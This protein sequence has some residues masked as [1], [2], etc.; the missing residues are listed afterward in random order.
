[1]ITG[2][3]SRGS[4]ENRTGSGP[5]TSRWTSFGSR[6][7]SSRGGR[8][9]YAQGKRGRQEF[10]LKKSQKEIFKELG[11]DY[12]HF[13]I[14][15]ENKDTLEVI[16]YLAKQLHMK[17][18]A[19]QF[20][21]NKDRRAVTSQRVSVYRVFPDKLASLNRSLRNA[22]VGDYIFQ[23]DKL[24]L[25]DLQ[26]NAF[27]IT[28]RDCVLKEDA[29]EAHSQLEILRER[30]RLGMEAMS[31][32]GFINYFGLQRF[33][34]FATRTDHIGKKLLQG[35][36]KDAVDSILEFSPA[37]L[38]AATDPESGPTISRDDRDRA[39]A[40]KIFRGGGPIKQALDTLPRKFS[41]ESNILRWLGDEEHKNDYRG[42]LDSIPRNLRSMYVHAYQSLI[43]NLAVTHRW[44]TLGDRLVAGDLVLVN[45]HEDKVPA[46][47]NEDVDAE[48][49][50]V[51][52]P[53]EEDRAVTANERFER[54]RALTAEEVA[55]GRYTIFDVVFPTPGFDILYPEYML[56][57]YKKTM[58][59]EQHGNLDPV[60]MVRKWK[61]ISL[62]GSYRKIVARP[63]AGFSWDVCV[64]EGEDKQLVSTDLDTVHAQRATPKKPGEEKLAIVTGTESTDA[65]RVKEQGADESGVDDGTGTGAEQ[66][67]V[68][69]ASSDQLPL[70]QVPDPAAVKRLGVVLNFKLG[71]S[72]YATMALRELMKQ[73]GAREYKPDFSAGRGMD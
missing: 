69:P 46:K 32:K 64:Y 27:C 37:A 67:E 66:L 53:A 22:K 68:A 48:G 57:F 15:K 1:M 36:F 45:E 42:A 71:T 30:V 55:S 49:E 2:I 21:G 44:K 31:D 63:L 56:P 34:S 20:A 13:T 26:G 70:D 4:T 17:P 12:L 62:S 40:L 9:G 72:Q 65:T 35:D 16:S 59:S 50:I 60:D 38:V 73:G 58:G 5:Q 61:E 3:D 51:I 29:T 41:A 11:G 14:Y 8:G 25:G 54:A 10:G 7:G 47:Q 39:M 33:G 28:L 52:K 19:F 24:A 43:W 23:E 6:G 18:N